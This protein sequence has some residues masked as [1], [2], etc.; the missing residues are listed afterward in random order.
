MPLGMHRNAPIGT[1]LQRLIGLLLLVLCALGWTQ[2]AAAANCYTATG[3]G[4]TGP[5]NWQTYCWLD[6]TSYNDAAARSGAGQNLS[7]TL[8]DGTVMTFNLKVSGA[9]VN[10][11]TSPSW[12]GAAVGNTAFTG[13]AG[14]PILYQTAA[15]T[16]VATISNVVMTPPSGAS[17]ITSYM[18]VAADAESSNDGETLR[19][20]TNGGAWTVLDQ[21][22]PISGTTYPTVTG[23]N[24][25]NVLT[26]GVAGTVG[27]YIF[28]STT[29]TTITTTMVGGGL[30]GA[31]FAVRFASIR[32]NQQITGTR[33][34]TADQFKFDI[35]ATASSAV[36][37]TGTTTGTGLGPFTAAAL[38]S[39]SALPL[40]LFQSMAGGSVSTQS[41]YRTTLTCTNAS[42]SSTVLPSNVTTTNYNF[43]TLQ[44]G[45]NVSC[46]FTSTP[47]PHLQ[48]R[49]VLGTGGR[50]FA[51]D[52]FIMT[53]EQ[54]GSVVA[55]TTTTGTGSTVINGFTPEIQATVGAIYTFEEAGAGA[56]SLDQYTQ[57]MACTNGWTGSSTALPT[58]VGGAVTPQMGDVILCTITNRRRAAN[59][60]LAISKSSELLSDPVTGSAA[61]FHIPGAIVR[62]RLDVLNSG[63]LSV[64]NNTVF[65]VDTLPADIRVGTAASPVFTQGTPTSG[66]TFNAGTDIRYSNA[67]GAPASFAACT[68]T[69]VAPYD[70]AVRHIC[71]N[72][73]GTMAG[74]TGTPPNF[75]IT[76]NAEVR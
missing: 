16:T 51:S 65:L 54:G 66:L 46:T 60:T 11:A 14:R 29:P 38:S 48:L 32:L 3:Q 25:T 68:Y 52:Q 49:K 19:F 30:Q 10:A 23:V 17:A 58:A 28:G 40:T 69:P 12:T 27:A 36:L 71:L 18:F 37:A 70:P 61:P 8:P 5:A 56:T 41:Q 22:G 53:I 33:V 4:S 2:P 63:S 74:S 35:R 1:S 43:G 75:S 31:M 64:D 67:A 50:R 44:F 13:I 15:G 72:P 45:D 9:A 6:L 20:Q 7:Y 73:K 57:T 47:F 76:F 34:D 39:S 26:T 42:V 21:S 62:Y 59:A 24:T 55:T